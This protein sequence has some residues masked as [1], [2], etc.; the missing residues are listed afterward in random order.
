M[1][2]VPPAA[3]PTQSPAANNAGWNN[4]DVTVA[5]NW[6]D[7]TGGSGIDAAHCTSSSTSTGQG[8]LLTLNATCKDRANNTG[9]ATYSV[10][11]DTTQPTIG[12]AT[13]TSPNTA[14]WYNSNVIA[15]FTCA[16]AVSGIPPT[17]CPSDEV[18]STEGEAVTSTR[19]TA[20]DVAGN[21]SEVSSIVT[22]KIDKTA[23][24]LT[25]QETTMPNGEGWYKSDVT[26][27]FTCTDAV[28]GIPAGACPADQVLT[29]EGVAVSS[30]AKSVNDAAGNISSSSNVVAVNIDKTAPSL[31]PIVSPNV[32]LLNGVTTVA[33]GATDSLSGLASQMCGAAETVSVGTKIV[34]CAATDKAGNTNTVSAIYRV[35]YP[36]TEFLQPVDNLPIL[37][38]VKAGSA[39]PVKFGLGGNQGMN[40]FASGYPASRSIGCDSGAPLDDIEQTLTAGSSSLSFDPFSGQYTY[41]WKTDKT[42]AVTCRQLVVRL[43]DGAEHVANFALK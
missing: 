32:V 6:M 10:K 9:T 20:I 11:V 17:G 7:N 14:G 3:S 12:V 4:G 37:N 33:S 19:T 38:R 39:I 30:L 31:S 16:D 27:H 18:L 22:V 1:D 29:S 42:W 8:S 24:T 21:I 35:I 41:I 2:S 23:P 40:I 43:A 15:H 34:D 13:T 26:V 5:W 25:A 36:W 28:S